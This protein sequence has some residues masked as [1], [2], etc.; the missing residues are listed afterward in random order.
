VATSNHRRTPCDL[1]ARNLQVVQAQ[2]LHALGK[3][4]PTSVCHG[5]TILPP[6]HE[7]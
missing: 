4:V 2:A 3:P 7:T 1:I 5:Y 6:T